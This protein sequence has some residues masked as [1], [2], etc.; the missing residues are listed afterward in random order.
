MLDVRSVL[1]R[2]VLRLF[3]TSIFI[4]FGERKDEYMRESLRRDMD[5]S[6]CKVKRKSLASGED[7]I[8]QSYLIAVTRDNGVCN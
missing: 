8:G 7:V 2:D 1:R 3:L 6:H 5:D 4:S